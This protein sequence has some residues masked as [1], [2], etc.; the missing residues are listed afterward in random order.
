[1]SARQ[2]PGTLAAKELKRMAR[3]PAVF[4]FPGFFPG[5]LDS[6]AGTV[7]DD[8]KLA[9][10]RAIAACV[11]ASELGEEYISPKRVQQKR[12]ASGGWRG[13]Q[14]GHGAPRRHLNPSELP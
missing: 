12:R 13:V 14:N 4:C 2:V 6:R 5:L 11:R 8:L 10:L 1:M 3:D 7:N 9:A